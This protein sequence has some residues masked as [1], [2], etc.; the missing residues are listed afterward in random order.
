MLEYK[1]SLTDLKKQLKDLRPKFGN[2]EDDLKK[3]LDYHMRAKKAI[4]NK[5][6]MDKVRAAKK[7]GTQTPASVPAS[8]PAPVKVPK[9]K[10][11]KTPKAPAPEEK[12]SAKKAA[13]MAQLAALG[14]D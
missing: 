13:L 14:S 2:T 7:S 3:E 9:E 4:E 11:P 1:M 6:R 10:V 8:V 5:E 12:V